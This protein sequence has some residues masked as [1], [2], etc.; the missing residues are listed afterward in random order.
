MKDFRRNNTIPNESKKEKLT[1]LNY[2]DKADKVMQNM[3]RTYY[4]KNGKERKKIDLSTSKI[5]KLLAMISELYNDVSREGINKKEKLSDEM[6]SRIQ[7]I[8]MYF[9][10]EA[11][12]ENGRENQVKDF[13]NKADIFEIIDDIGSDRKKLINFCHYMEALVAY[14]KYYAPDKE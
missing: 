9:A 5:R 6:L 7:Y 4:T 2:V 13:V 14:R 3:T 12:R 8:K 10:Y 11:G 1:E